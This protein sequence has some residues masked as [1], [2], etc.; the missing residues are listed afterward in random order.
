M[1]STLRK[2]DLIRIY[3]IPFITMLVSSMAWSISIVYA[4]ELGA[5]IYQVNLLRS[6]RTLMGILLLVPIGVLSDRFGRKGM[7]I[8][9]R[10][11]T[12]FGVLIRAFATNVRHLYIASIVG[13]VAGRGFFPVLLSMIGDIAE[14]E[15]SQEAVSLLY[16]FSSIGLIVGPSITSLLLTSE[17]VKLRGVYQIAVV[18]QLTVLI[19]L[20]TQI[21]ET[22]TQ[23]RKGGKFDFSSVKDLIHQQRFQSLSLMALFYFF[24]RSI[25]QTYIPIYAKMDLDL[26]DGQVASLSTYHSTG[27][28]VIRLLSAT[29]LTRAPFNTLLY[30]FLALGG[31]AG[32]TA[33]SANNYYT[34]TIAIVISGLSYGAVRILGA[35]DIAKQTTP[36]NRG[37]ANSL[38]NVSIS[39]GDII[40]TFTAPIADLF[41]TNP[42]FMLATIT[43]LASTIPVTTLTEEH[44]ENT[45]P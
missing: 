30:T 31:V 4:L 2:P 17:L 14:E 18:A 34:L 16:L 35:T 43:A 19:Y 28:L 32:L 40:R 36:K 21:E 23:S 24:S 33:I 12:F 41:G 11:I 1:L 37:L 25:L 29:L 39:A 6:I 38:Y 27:I 22:G 9:S 7:V 10:L 15:E 26:S 20:A 13:G 5:N 42:I 8:Y 44:T 45:K 3:L